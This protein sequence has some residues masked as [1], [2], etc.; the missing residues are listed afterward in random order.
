M[1]NILGGGSVLVSYYLAKANEELSPSDIVQFI[2]IDK[3]NNH[4]FLPLGRNAL[5]QKFFF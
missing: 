1:A 2:F 4:I 3:K 5:A